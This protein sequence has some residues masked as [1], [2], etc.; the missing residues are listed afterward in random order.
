MHRRATSNSQPSATVPEQ[1]AVDPGSHFGQPPAA[2]NDD[3]SF[4]TARRALALESPS[5]SSSHLNGDES[6]VAETKQFQKIRLDTTPDE[7][8]DMQLG[9]AATTSPLVVTQEGGSRREGSACPISSVD[10][11]AEA[12]TPKPTSGLSLVVD[13]SQDDDLGIIEVDVPAADGFDLEV[14]EDEVLGDEEGDE[15]DEDGDTDYRGRAKS[16][17]TMSTYPGVQPAF[18]VEYPFQHNS[19]RDSATMCVMFHSCVLCVRVC[20]RMCVSNVLFWLLE[21]RPQSQ[22]FANDY[23]SL[24]TETRRGRCMPMI[25][26]LL[27]KMGA[28]TAATISCLSTRRSRRDNT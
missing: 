2:H 12:S 6:R 25:T 15:A 14:D 21:T 7:A 22:Y 24:R 10:F 8:G 19:G 28:N 18:Q 27:Q 16:V 23:L 13:D 9:E 17:F 5:P 4:T 11:A 20:A 1:T 26:T 3:S